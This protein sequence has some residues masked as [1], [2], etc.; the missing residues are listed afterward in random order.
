MDAREGRGADFHVT[1][2]ARI[3]GRAIALDMPVPHR[4]RAGV[5]G[6]NLVVR[7]LLPSRVR[8][9]F[10]LSWTPVH[11][12]A[13]RTI[14]AG[15]RA[16]QRVVPDRA[17]LGRNTPLFRLVTDTERRIIARG[18]RTIDYSGT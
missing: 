9:A 3:V 13:Y 12:A 10:G 14:T 15:V 1:T 8:H 18:G 11:A 17:R 5:A 2:E 16:S 6:T 4:L 7:G